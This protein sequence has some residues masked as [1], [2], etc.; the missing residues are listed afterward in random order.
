M[1][2]YRKQE[3]VD[4]ETFDETKDYTPHQLD[5]YANA[6]LKD[7]IRENGNVNN[8]LLPDHLISRSRREHL[9]DSS[10]I[11]G[12]ITQMLSPKDRPVDHS[13]DNQRLYNRSHPKGRKVNSKKARKSSGASYYR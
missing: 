3:Q 8:I 1:A 12:T 2:W 13:G 10:N 7:D 4:F 9:V 11:D 5:L 6:L